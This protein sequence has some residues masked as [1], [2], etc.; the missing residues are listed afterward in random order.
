M[1]CL[2]ALLVTF[3]YSYYKTGR[4]RIALTFVIAVIGIVMAYYLFDI[5]FVILNRFSTQGMQD[6]GRLEN[7]VKGV[8]AVFDSGGLGIGVGNYAP[9]L[10]NI[11]N[12]RIAAPHNLL[13]EVG[14]CFGLP[15]LLGFLGML[16]R[17]FVN[18][19]NSVLLLFSYLS[20]CA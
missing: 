9:V 10:E 18:G 1:L 2:G 20:E 13:L 11:Y 8:Q 5:F 3:V 12:V 15:V 14:V 19:M 7:I 17:V 6:T 4:N 16:V